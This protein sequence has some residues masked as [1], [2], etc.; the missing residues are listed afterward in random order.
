MTKR[1]FKRTA[2]KALKVVSIVAG[3]YLIIVIFG[4][5]PVKE[6]YNIS[7]QQE[8]WRAAVKITLQILKLLFGMT[9]SFF[10]MVILYR[11]GQHLVDKNRED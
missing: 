7:M 4:I 1:R 3:L 2:G 10:G 5:Q 9:Y 8:G 6:I 11:W